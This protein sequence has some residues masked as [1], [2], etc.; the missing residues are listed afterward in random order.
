MSRLLQDYRKVCAAVELQSLAE[1]GCMLVGPSTHQLTEAFSK[2]MFAGEHEV[3]GFPQRVPVWKVLG[4]TAVESRFISARAAAAG[5]IL[6]R[7]REMAFLADAW[8]RATH[9]NGH[10][11]VLS[12]EAGMGKSRLL[13][14]LAERVGTRRIDYCARN[15]HRITA[16]PCCTQFC[17]CCV[18]SST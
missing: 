14:A 5:P 8:Q 4:E 18:S 9:G 10:V 7:E 17:S 16:T 1:P 11:V 12:G 13:E 15:A 2:Y 6:G 3:K